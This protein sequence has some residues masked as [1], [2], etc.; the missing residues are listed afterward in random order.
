MST[1]SYR[2]T[3][4]TNLLKLLNN[5]FQKRLEVITYSGLFRLCSLLCVLTNDPHWHLLHHMQTECNQ[6]LLQTVFTTLNVPAA[7]Q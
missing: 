3:I 6:F 5:S 2:A 4:L 1:M 7:L